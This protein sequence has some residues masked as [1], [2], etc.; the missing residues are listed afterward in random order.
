MMKKISVRMQKI[1]MSAFSAFALMVTVGASNGVCI[2][3]A[4]QPKP[5]KAFDKYR[6]HL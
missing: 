5:P 2:F 6:R 3:V 1:V 4:H